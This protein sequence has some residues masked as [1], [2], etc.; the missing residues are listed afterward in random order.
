MNINLLYAGIKDEYSKKQYLAY[1]HTARLCYLDYKYEG[2][3]SHLENDVGSLRVFCKKCCCVMSQG[4]VARTVEGWNVLVSC[5]C[6]KTNRRF[7]V[8]D[9]ELKYNEMVAIAYLTALH[10]G[11]RI[12]R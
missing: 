12:K 8:T 11:K 5:K 9:D 7:S 1:R 3:Y 4:Q 6:Y 10:E 2:K